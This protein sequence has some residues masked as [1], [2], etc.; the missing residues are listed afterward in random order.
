MEGNGRSGHPWPSYPEPHSWEGLPREAG[1]GGS[2]SL[3]AQLIRERSSQPWRGGQAGNS[4]C[5]DMVPGTKHPSVETNQNMQ[6]KKQ[7]E[8]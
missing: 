7:W 3:V 4:G 6:V 5:S 2:G 1:E 8:T